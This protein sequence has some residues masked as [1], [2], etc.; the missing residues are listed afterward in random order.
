MAKGTA[1]GV[2]REAFHPGDVAF[3][4]ISAPRARPSPPL[5]TLRK[6]SSQI[7]FI[8]TAGS[9]GSCGAGAPA[10]VQGV[11]AHETRGRLNRD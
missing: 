10:A 6:H 3:P 11:I 5:F 7:H 2:P 4:Q 1:S 8:R 9:G